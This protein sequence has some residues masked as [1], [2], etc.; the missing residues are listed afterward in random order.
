[1]VNFFFHINK[2]IMG[3]DF[4][5][6]KLPT[7]TFWDGRGQFK[8]GLLDLGVLEAVVSSPEVFTAVFCGI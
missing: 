2:I 5:L 6:N 8:Q 4:S 3:H 7:G 1:M